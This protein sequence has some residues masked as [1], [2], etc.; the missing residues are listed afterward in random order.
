[1]DDEAI[2]DLATV[3]FGRWDEIADL[4]LQFGTIAEINGDF[5]GRPLYTEDE[6]L[7]MLFEVRAIAALLARSPKIKREGIKARM[8]RTLEPGNPFWTPGSHFET[9]EVW[10]VWTRKKVD[11]LLKQFSI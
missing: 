4:L 8:M 6:R 3:T 7:T 1:M 5:D 11:A 10:E 9:G 2:A